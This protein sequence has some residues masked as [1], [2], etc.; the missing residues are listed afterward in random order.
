[1]KARLSFAQKVHLSC[2]DHIRTGSG[3]DRP[4]VLRSKMEP[5]KGRS[6]VTSHTAVSLAGR[7]GSRF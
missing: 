4:D 3:S 6:R 1:M 5:M 7:Y 2:R